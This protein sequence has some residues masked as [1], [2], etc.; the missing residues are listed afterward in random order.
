MRWARRSSPQS[1]KRISDTNPIRPPTLTVEPARVLGAEM[2]K[3]LVHALNT[4]KR[5]ALVSYYLGQVIANVDTLKQQVRT[6]EDLYDYLLIDP[7]VGSQVM[8]SELGE[9][10]AS[11][12]QYINRVVQGREPRV[13]ASA[14]EVARWQ[15]GENR[16]A[17]WAGLQQLR[18][19]PEN[20]IDP[21][22][23]VSKTELFKALESRLSQGRINNDLVQ[24]AIL[25]YLN[26]FEEISNL[27]IIAC[28]EDG[29]KPLVDTFYFI[30]RTKMSPY[31]Y[32]WRSL[33]M[34]RRYK[35]DQLYPTAWSEWKKIETSLD[36]AIPSTVRPVFMNGRLYVAWCESREEKDE[37]G[38]VSRVEVTFKLAHKRFNDSWS[39]PHNVYNR[40]IEK[41]QEPDHLIAVVD[42][43][44]GIEYLCLYAVAK[45]QSEQKLRFICD[46]LMNIIDGGSGEESATL[47]ELYTSFSAPDVVQHPYKEGVYQVVVGAREDI[48]RVGANQNTEIVFN[49]KIDGDKLAFTSE[50]SPGCFPEGFERVLGQDPKLQ[51]VFEIQGQDILKEQAKQVSDFQHHGS[52][53]Y[54]QVALSKLLSEQ[55]VRTLWIR[56]GM[57]FQL[58]G[59]QRGCWA[60]DV[61]TLTKTQNLHQTRV[62]TDGKT[63]AQFLTLHGSMKEAKKPESR[64]SL[65]SPLRLNTLFAKSLIKQA[66][67]GVERVLTETQWISEPA[68]KANDAE[69]PIDFAGANSLY[70]W[71]LF[72]HTPFL[73]AHRLNVEQRFD[74]ATHWLHFLFYPAAERGEYWKVRPLQGLNAG[75]PTPLADDGETDPDALAMVAPVRYQKAVFFKYLKNL[76]DRGDAC[77]RELSRDG[78][79]QAK[80]WYK[81]ALTLIGDRPQVKLVRRWEPVRLDEGMKQNQ[82]ARRQGA[83]EKSVKGVTGIFTLPINH[84]L[85]E[86]W[87][88]LETRLYNL[89]HSLTLDGKPLSL[90]LFNKP[91][92]PSELLAARAAGAVQSGGG[93][94]GPLQVPPYRYSQMI[95]KAYAAVETLMQFGS[96]LLLALERKDGAQLERLQHL[97]QGELL[98]FTLDMQLQSIKMGDANKAMLEYSKSAA[99]ARLKHYDELLKEG[100][101]DLEVAALGVRGGAM[102]AAHAGNALR[103]AGGF[104]DLAPNVF[105]FSNGG[106]RYS[107]P[108]QAAGE[109]VLSI[110]DA[111]MQSALM[112]ETTEQ[113]RRRAQEWQLLRNQAEI[114]VRQ[115][116]AQI[117]LEE[118]QGQLLQTQLEQLHTQQRHNRAQLDFLSTR[119]S[120]EPLYQWMV[121][122]LAPLYFQAY[123]GVMSLCLATEA[124]WQYET[125][126][127][128]RPRFIQPGAWS[129]LYRGLL[130]GEALK[131]GLQRMDQAYLLR[132][133]RKL[134]IVHTLSLKK[135]LG[136]DWLEEL[137]K[138]KSEGKLAFDLTQDHF[139]ERYP[140]HYLRQIVTLSVSLPAVVGPYQDIRA[141]LT[142]TRSLFATQPRMEAVKYLKGDGGSADCVQANLRAN[143][144]IALSTGI[145]D[146]GMFVLNFADERYLPF[147][148]TGAVSS[149]QLEFP[150]PKHPEQRA[151]LETLR[152]VILRIRYTAR[153]GGAVFAK[154]VKASL[155]TAPEVKA[156]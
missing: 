140:G 115:V 41:D 118:E 27:Q 60:K 139:D 142:Q 141:M 122:K 83:I 131:H 120:N 137:K 49:V 25:D 121:S 152:D 58:D 45:G 71:E 53:Q 57:E 112:M 138:L 89:R 149:W 6:A 42:G 86:Y 78:L 85:N 1:L 108:M 61:I 35:D 10:I 127:F 84:T 8:T 12:Q 40:E 46:P 114:E 129:D 70:F 156:T 39:E 59:R 75:A 130:A 148:G 31:Q 126:I 48:V 143:Q 14:M 81:L 117:E 73:V 82:A 63:G 94:G 116:T 102:V 110:A 7:L 145:D 36:G 151:M 146:S 15:D 80:Q 56:H 91:R 72:F 33:N 134:E 43:T 21:P 54:S 153:D 92:N 124:A 20:Y 69:V 2:N 111:A 154:E 150:N 3:E 144:Q 18:A 155:P 100:L 24:E 47:K 66:N 123:D 136:T 106:M 90:P 65:H 125:G 55:D 17:V 103:I 104:A 19:Y 147:E 64:E 95:N 128:D 52:R 62:H 9:A 93:Q 4:A 109:A 13:V 101:S 113:Y 50:V 30:G 88:D 98:A 11:T 68:F 87:T 32:Y 51:H 37:K 22:L 132:N 5:D 26:G 119:F 74:E 97:Q 105:G 77:Y 34:R 16:Y 133:E 79:A 107:S 67:A 28:Y 29:L 135:L 99:E 23:R 76:M 38:S 96:T 44:S